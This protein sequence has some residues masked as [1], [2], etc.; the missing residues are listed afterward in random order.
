MRRRIGSVRS[1]ARS[2]IEECP[3]SRHRPITQVRQQHVRDGGVVLEHIAFRVLA[4]REDDAIEV[5]EFDV[6]FGL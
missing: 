1:R 6:V 5:R 2:A 3:P 4:F